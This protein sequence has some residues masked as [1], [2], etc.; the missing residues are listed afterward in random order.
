MLETG[1]KEKSSAPKEF[2]LK[3]SLLM[4]NNMFWSSTLDFHLGKLLDRAYAGDAGKKTIKNWLG[5]A[6]EKNVVIIQLDFPSDPLLLQ[7]RPEGWS[8]KVLDE[9]QS[10]QAD[11]EL[12]S[13]HISLI[14]F[15]DSLRSFIHAL[16]RGSL[17]LPMLWQKP[18]DHYYAMRIF[19]G[20]NHV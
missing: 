3:D 16:L 10:V 13:E 8:A 11:V 14:A 7:F 9:G 12:C 2:I 1:K 17:K 15:T 6:R 19:L 18:R 5:S 4:H 20:G